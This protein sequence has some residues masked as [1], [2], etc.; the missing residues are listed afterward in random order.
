MPSLGKISLGIGVMAAAFWI[1]LAFLKDD[2]PIQVVEA[3]FGLNCKDYKVK[4]PNENKVF[5]GNFTKAVKDVCASHPNECTFKIYI[6]EDLGTG[7]PANGCEKDFSV[8]WKCG[9]KGDIHRAHATP[10]AENK[11]VFLSC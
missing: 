3:T 6:D 5:I 7:D 1:T 4:P 10:P 8:A 2:V 11:S 9:D